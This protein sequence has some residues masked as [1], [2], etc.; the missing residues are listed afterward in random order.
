MAVVEDPFFVF[1]FFF[2]FGDGQSLRSSEYF[3]LNY[4]LNC[5]KVPET[6]QKE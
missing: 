1:F 5:Q 4:L 6:V 3:M 2:L